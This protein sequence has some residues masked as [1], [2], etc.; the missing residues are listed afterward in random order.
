MVHKWNGNDY[1]L[2]IQ[3]YNFITNMKGHEFGGYGNFFLS[4]FFQY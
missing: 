3:T 1:V 4:G 2:S